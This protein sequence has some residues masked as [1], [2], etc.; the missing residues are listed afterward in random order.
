[1][2]AHSFTVSIP[3]S[4]TCTLVLFSLFLVF[5]PLNFPS[6]SAHSYC[7]VSC[8]HSP[9]LCF[10]WAAEL[11]RCHVP[12]VIHCAK[13]G[14]PAGRAP[15]ACLRLCEAAEPP[16][17]PGANL[18]RGACQLMQLPSE[19]WLHQ[20]LCCRLCMSA[21]KTLVYSACLDPIYLSS[22]TTAGDMTKK[23]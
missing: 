22:I 13:I 11:W 10:L 4:L 9:C 21:D 14:Q 12:A 23:K 15:C 2:L 3:C 7:S 16:H 17:C 6:L 8:S 1:M 20:V 18:H 19:I 5:Y